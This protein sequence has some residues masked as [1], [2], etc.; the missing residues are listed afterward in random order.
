MR[1]C[2]KITTIDYGLKMSPE[3]VLKIADSER[4]LLQPELKAI[5]EG[6]IYAEKEGA[7]YF[8]KSIYRGYLN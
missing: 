5:K 8:K 6:L 7:F 2:E 3:T 4:W 1:N